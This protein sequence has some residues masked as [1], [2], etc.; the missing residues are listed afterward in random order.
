MNV[1]RSRGWQPCRGERVIVGPRLMPRK[2]VTG[3]AL[4]AG[5]WVLGPGGREVGMVADPLL[6][7]GP[8]CSASSPCSVVLCGAVVL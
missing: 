6:E 4:G 5:C 3:A 2:A 1:N 7:L 8:S